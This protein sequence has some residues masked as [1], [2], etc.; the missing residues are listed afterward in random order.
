MPRYT[1]RK[2]EHLLKR[3]EF[4][5]V[6][7]SGNQYVG[8]YLRIS[9]LCS[10]PDKKLGI[11]AG[12]KTGCAVLRNRFKRLIRE[13]YRLNKHLLPEGLH[14]VVSAFRYEDTL[15]FKLIEVDFLDM[16]KKA[17]LL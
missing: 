15:K 1:F 16:C 13:T 7:S 11:I 3:W 6:Y 10:Q 2:S 5:R 12:R 14:I 17:G 8:K 4:E 9:V